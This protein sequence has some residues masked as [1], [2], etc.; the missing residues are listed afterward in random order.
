MAPMDIAYVASAGAVGLALAVTVWAW[1]A[2]VDILRRERELAGREAGGA[3]TL[4]DAR[5]AA[6]AIE[7]AVIPPWPAPS[8]M[9]L[10]IKPPTPPSA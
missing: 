1:R 4:A 7:G 2:R 3:Q 8:C 9:L 5:G 6:E 10:P